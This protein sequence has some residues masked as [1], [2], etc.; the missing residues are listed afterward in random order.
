MSTNSL[1][2]ILSQ[3]LTILKNKPKKIYEDINCINIDTGHPTNIC[4]EHSNEC[5]SCISLQ[6]ISTVHKKYIPS[7]RYND[8]IT[9]IL[10]CDEYKQELPTI[11]FCCIRLKCKKVV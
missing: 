5:Q 9:E 7:T 10:I 3:S 8:S 2:K 1:K 11:L 6:D 4:L